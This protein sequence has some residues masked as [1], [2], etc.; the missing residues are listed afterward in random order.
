AASAELGLADLRFIACVTEAFAERLRGG[1]FRHQRFGRTLLSCVSI[2]HVPNPLSLCIAKN[3][4]GQPGIP[5]FSGWWD[6][7][8]GLLGVLRVGGRPVLPRPYQSKM[9]EHDRFLAVGFD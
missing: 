7:D 4:N 6:S 1:L 5:D 3:G 2:C 8:G 9:P